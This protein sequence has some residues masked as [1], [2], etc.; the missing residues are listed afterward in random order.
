MPLR[1]LLITALIAGGYEF[2]KWKI[3]FQLADWKFWVVISFFALTTFVTHRMLVSS[4]DGRPAQF[5]N[6]FMGGILLK[7]FLGFIVFITL[8]LISVKDELIPL[9]VIFVS[10]YIIYTIIGS[11]ESMKL[12]SSNDVPKT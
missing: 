11:S 12:K 9:G 8:A 2:A 3:A 5:A 1:L 4:I 7:L 10:C 6:R